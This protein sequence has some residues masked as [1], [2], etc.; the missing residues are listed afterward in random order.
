M[1]LGRIIGKTSTNQFS[2]LATAHPHTSSPEGSAELNSPMPVQKFNYV[3][4]MGREGYV[5][6]QIVEIRKEKNTTVADC[7][8]I[9]YREHNQLQRLRTPLEPNTEVLKPEGSFIIS[10]LGLEKENNAYIGTLENYPDIKVNLDLKKLLTHKVAVLARTGSGKSYTT[11]V[12]IEE[13]LEKKIPLL[14]I[15]PHGEYSSLRY[16][17]PDNKE[18]LLRFGIKPKGFNEQ[19][20]EFSPDTKANPNALPLKLSKNIL[21][22][23]DLI[24][25]LPAKLSNTQLGLLYS[26]IKN[27]DL[28]DFESLILHLEAEENN[29]KYTLINIIE[30]IQKLDLFSHAPTELTDIIKP[31][32]CSII[33]LRGVDIELQEVVVYK[34]L[35]DLFEAR[36]RGDIPPFFVVIEEAQNFIPE[37]NFGE[38]K[39]S[40]II[41]Q[42]AAE[43][44]KFGIGL[45]LITQR[46]SR[47]EKNALS[48]CSTQIILKITN[49]SD[50]R[51][52]SS[53]AEGL[54]TETEKE[55]RNTP[56][57]TAM[58]VGVVDL[59]LFVNIRP[60][61]TKHGGESV[62]ILNSMIQSG[63]QT[64]ELMPIIQPPITSKDREL[65]S[66]KKITTTLIPCLFLGLNKFNLLIN[67]NTGK[68]I[69]KI[70]HPEGKIIP[71]NRELSPQQ[72]RIFSV[73]IKLKKFTAAEIFAK[74]GVQFSEIYDILSYFTGEGYISKTG[75]S[76]QLNETLD[77]ESSAFYGKPEFIRTH[78][79]QKLPKNHDPL[80]IKTAIQEL[81]PIISSKECWLAKYDEVE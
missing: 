62:D 16:P 9:G 4:V 76:Y 48:Q 3:Q 40:R 37:R 19:I 13:I 31:G 75:N 20:Q 28:P 52:V 36:K 18:K 67:L 50:L 77:L 63:D 69:K 22:S 74:S 51:S 2:F 57:G 81:L 23:S 64:N 12:L 45:C 72:K 80:K 60:R 30:Y 41:R 53:S 1:I 54:T 27:M 55:I 33:N 24:H 71:L 34:L 61:K 66:G 21:S 39:S 14:I 65:M 6:A 32:K 42:I 25:L 73:A 79:D 47:I 78:Y 44:R 26:A 49:P 38:A 70:E 11:S 7:S 8:V 43:S 56:I 59:P 29:M 5:L 46:P 58:I 35:K 10:T 17:N 68:L 15:D